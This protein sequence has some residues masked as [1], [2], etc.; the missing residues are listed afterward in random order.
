MVSIIPAG[1]DRHCVMYQPRIEQVKSPVLG[2]QVPN[3]N[4]NTR[5]NADISTGSNFQSTSGYIQHQARNI[6]NSNVQGTSRVSR[7]YAQNVG[8]SNG[9]DMKNVH[10]RSA[11]MPEDVYLKVH[12]HQQQTAIVPPNHF[13]PLELPHQNQTGPTSHVYNQRLVPAQ[14]ALAPAPQGMNKPVIPHLSQY[15][16][17]FIKVHPKPY[18]TSSYSQHSIYGQLPHQPH[19]PPVSLRRSQTN[20]GDYLGRRKEAKLSTFHGK[21]QPSPLMR[22]LSPHLQSSSGL[23]NRG[24]NLPEQVDRVMNLDGSMQ[25]IHRLGYGAARQ[26]AGLARSRSNI[27]AI[28][29]AS[30]MPHTQHRVMDRDP[31]YQQAINLRPQ[32]I[33][34]RSNLARATS[35][36]HPSSAGPKY[37]SNDTFVLQHSGHMRSTSMLASMTSGVPSTAGEKNLAG[38]RKQ[39]GKDVCKPLHVDCSIEYDLGN[40]PK[41][42]KNSAPLLIIHP[43]YHNAKIHENEDNEIKK[44]TRSA[45]PKTNRYQQ[46]VPQLRNGRGLTRHSS[47]A[48]PSSIDHASRKLM[49]LNLEQEFPDHSLNKIGSSLALSKSSSN[50]GT[51]NQ[52]HR[53]MQNEHGNVPASKQLKF[54][55]RRNENKEK[56]MLE[57]EKESVHLSMLDITTERE[58]ANEKENYI[59]KGDMIP[60]R[61]N[62]RKCVSIVRRGTSVTASSKPTFP[63]E[64]RNSN[65][66]QLMGKQSTKQKQ[67][68]KALSTIN[69]KLLASRKMSTGSRDSGA[70]SSLEADSSGGFNSFL[71]TMT[72]VSSLG[73]SGIGEGKGDTILMNKESSSPSPNPETIDENSPSMLKIL[74]GGRTKR[75]AK[76]VNTPYRDEDQLHLNAKAVT[77]IK[78]TNQET[79]DTQNQIAPNKMP[80]STTNVKLIQNRFTQQVQNLSNNFC[81][82]GLGTPSSLNEATKYP[83]GCNRDL[84][85]GNTMI[86]AT[87]NGKIPSSI[88]G[89]ISNNSSTQ[90]TNS[91]KG[92]YGYAMKGYVTSSSSSSSTS[93]WKSSMSGKKRL[94]LKCMIICT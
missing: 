56:R 28:R 90:N 15:Y 74:N 37:L 63:Q 25:N 18:P 83:V 1:N 12:H 52:L 53:R 50:L 80:M 70:A 43:A 23:L 79:S 34:R 17:P 3:Y 20:A 75:V 44:L 24:S 13:Q 32:H 38:S 22:A 9:E 39:L 26:N 62:D 2:F 46:N 82:S 30:G 55:T 27:A 45:P 84:N 40:Q 33:G 65:P 87:P 88:I 8:A 85:V 67:H 66:I 76:S 78:I 94:S 51:N 72:V 41:I 89:S 57:R 31:I 19:Q 86:S 71:S 42:P 54:D 93:K 60:N 61:N 49:P 91:S 81:D 47:F 69:G 16:G 73:S 10:T 58:D 59:A 48:H 36:Y 64:Y 6:Q 77:K 68:L 35:F 4:K 7:N 11:S 14:L 29:G 21:S 5:T 92:S